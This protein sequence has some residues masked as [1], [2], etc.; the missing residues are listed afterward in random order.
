MSRE[1][2]DDEVEWASE[3]SFIDVE[4]DDDKKFIASCWL[5]RVELVSK[6]FYERMETSR[7]RNPLR[8]CH[9]KKLS[10]HHTQ[11]EVARNFLAT[12]RREHEKIFLHVP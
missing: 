3:K 2:S 9:Q 12:R 6:K 1:H 5:S 8:T 11:L 4:N 7:D 10:I